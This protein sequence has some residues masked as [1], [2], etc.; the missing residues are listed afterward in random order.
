[1]SMAKYGLTSSLRGALKRTSNFNITSGVGGEKKNRF[2]VCLCWSAQCSHT[3]SSATDPPRCSLVSVGGER[4]SFYLRVPPLI[5][6]CGRHFPIVIPL[7]E[8]RSPETRGQA[9][10]RRATPTL[11]NRQQSDGEQSSG[12]REKSCRLPSH[13]LLLLLLL[14]EWGEGW[15]YHHGNGLFAPPLFSRVAC[16]RLGQAL[17]PPYLLPLTLHHPLL[18]SVCLP[19][20]L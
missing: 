18:H 20:S 17:T 12:V 13:G 11:Q 5:H 9:V 15:T 6:G 8:C 3:A 7:C 14:P 2:S 10:R 16:K 19:C 1:M 4:V